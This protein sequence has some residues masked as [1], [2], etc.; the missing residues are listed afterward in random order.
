MPHAHNA[1]ALNGFIYRKSIVCS[2]FNQL[3][4][5]HK[6]PMNLSLALGLHGARTCHFI[7]KRKHSSHFG[8]HRAK[9]HLATTRRTAETVRRSSSLNRDV[10]THHIAVTPVSVQVIFQT[11]LDEDANH[12]KTLKP[13]PLNG[14]DGLFIIIAPTRYLPGATMMQRCLGGIIIIIILRRH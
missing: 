4:C 5:A 3:L 2:D 7:T 1:Q 6:M 10:H 9:T 13:V 14:D 12:K 8:F 11:S